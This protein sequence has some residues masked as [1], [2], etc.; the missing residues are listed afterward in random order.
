MLPV[1]LL[2]QMQGS[3]T[4][5]SGA[6]DFSSIQQAVDSLSKQGVSAAVELVFTKPKL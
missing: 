4:I 2:G 1:W 6:H 3:Y 5:G